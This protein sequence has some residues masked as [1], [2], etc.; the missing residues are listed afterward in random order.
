[1]RYLDMLA[2]F[3]AAADNDQQFLQFIQ[4]PKGSFLTFDKGYNNYQQFA[5]FSV[6]EVFFITRQKDNAVYKTI[7]EKILTNQVPDAVLK[8]E[9]I[10]IN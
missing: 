8:E 2:H 5:S 3:N 6:S 9:T 7:S 1:C 10:E 4:L